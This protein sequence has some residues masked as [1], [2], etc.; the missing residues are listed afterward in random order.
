MADAAD[1]L[2]MSP[3]LEAIPKLFE[4]A[5]LSVKQARWNTRWAIGYNLIAVSL[6]CGVFE[7]WGLAI[8]A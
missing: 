1:V 2:I 8:N 7:R 5:R 4:I 6:A 3:S